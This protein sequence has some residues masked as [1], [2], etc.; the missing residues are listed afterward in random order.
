VEKLLLILAISRHNHGNYFQEN[1]SKSSRK[2][3]NAPLSAVFS[4]KK[5]VSIWERLVVCEAADKNEL[6]FLKRKSIYV[7]F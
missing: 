5:R 1:R 4:G 6:L 2:G 7:I 3:L